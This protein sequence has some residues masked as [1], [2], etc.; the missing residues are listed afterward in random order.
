MFDNN[1][2]TPLQK[3]DHPL[4]LDMSIN[5]LMKRDDMIHPEISGNKWRKL[6]YNLLH[7]KK[8]GIERILTF[9]GAYSNHIAATAAACRIYGIS[10]IGFIRGDELN[11]QS[12]KTLAKA[13]QDGME[14]HFISRATY[15]QREDLAWVDQLAHQYNALVIPEG[16]SNT[17][18]LKG[19]EE[20]VADIDIDFHIL[21]CAVG[22]GGTLAGLSK[23][24]HP[25]QIAIGIA[26]LKGE[27]YLEDNIKSLLKSKG[28]SEN[29]KI[30]HDYHFG[31]YA[32][33]DAHL[34]H[35]INEFHHVTDIPLDPI[36]TGKLMYG[37]FDLIKK[38]HFKENTTIITLHS[39]GLQ[40][41]E[42]F[43]TQNGNLLKFNG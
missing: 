33:F 24:L 13:H 40:G 39:G 5:L 43:N 15:R 16:G 7:A 36:Y 32:K 8:N 6:K 28:Q 29:W 2:S 10:S 20:V 9:G 37:M 14:L 17:L 27:K 21:A 34:I 3:I 26:A 18:A 12:N 38:G 42:G 23:S 11:H 22:T 30:N 1:I 25:D 41:I 35:F 4:L 19:L 31:G